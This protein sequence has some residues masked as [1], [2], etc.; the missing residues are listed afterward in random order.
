MPVFNDILYHPT[1]LSMDIQYKSLNSTAGLDI[2]EK[3]KVSCPCRKSKYV[4]LDARCQV[5]LPLSHHCC[6]SVQKTYV[7]KA[8]IQERHTAELSEAYVSSFGNTWLRSAEIKN[9]RK[10]WNN[11]IVIT[12]TLYGIY[13]HICMHPA[14]HAFW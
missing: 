12:H 8:N 9:W 7:Y 4:I 3:F 10:M 14:Q 11:F 5:T 1:N 6:R 13:I 2:L